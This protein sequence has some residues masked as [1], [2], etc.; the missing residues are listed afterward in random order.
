MKGCKRPEHV[1]KQISETMSKRKVQPVIQY[2]MT[3]NKVAKYKSMREAER[4]TGVRAGN[5]SGCCLGY[6]HTAGG[7]VWKYASPQNSR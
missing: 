3:G 2:D 5:I 7:Y 4:Q 6:F 1:K